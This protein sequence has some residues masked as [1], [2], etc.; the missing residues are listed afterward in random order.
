MTAA[1]LYVLYSICI[2]L[3]LFFALAPELRPLLYRIKHF[4]FTDLRH[5]RTVFAMDRNC[6]SV[7]WTF[8]LTYYG[9]HIPSPFC[10]IAMH[11]SSFMQCRQRYIPLVS[12]CCQRGGEARLSRR[13]H[14]PQSGFH[15]CKIAGGRKFKSTPRYYFFQTG[16]LSFQ[17]RTFVTALSDA[18]VLLALGCIIQF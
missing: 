18:C 10:V 17:C 15:F 6:I 16:I 13:A 4:R 5:L 2:S 14:N 11:L 12:R 9:L 8:L 7:K 3:F 1:A